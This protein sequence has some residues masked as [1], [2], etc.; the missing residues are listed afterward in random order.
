M[1]IY[2]PAVFTP[3][4]SLFQLLTGINSRFYFFLSAVI[5]WLNVQNRHVKSCSSEGIGA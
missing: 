5:D 1:S 4:L 2:L 3:G